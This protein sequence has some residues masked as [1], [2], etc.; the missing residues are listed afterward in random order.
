MLDL[1]A[2]RNAE[3]ISVREVGLSVLIVRSIIETLGLCLLVSVCILGGLVGAYVGTR[4]DTPVT[5]PF[6]S[7]RTEAT[8]LA[9]PVLVG[10]MLLKTPR[11]GLIRNGTD[12]SASSVMN[13]HPDDGSSC[14]NH[15]AL[16]GIELQH[17]R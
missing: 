12:S 17:A 5:F 8:A 13:T 14:C 2:R 9:A 16:A 7:G 11:P 4:I 3:R 10:M 6:S 1:D 15:P